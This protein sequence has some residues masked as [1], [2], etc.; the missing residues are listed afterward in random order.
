MWI[1]RQISKDV[2]SSAWNPISNARSRTP[3][4]EPRGEYIIP[5]RGE[6]V[7]CTSVV[8]SGEGCVV[9][10]DVCECV[11]PMGARGVVNA[12]RGACSGGFISHGSRFDVS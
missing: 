6:V 8:G 2:S 1:W 10:G 7:Q 3:F 5:S 9:E 11:Q 4:S 12:G